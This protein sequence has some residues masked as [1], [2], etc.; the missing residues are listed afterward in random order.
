MVVVV[1]GAVV[2]IAMDVGVVN[3]GTWSLGLCLGV[4][5]WRE[6]VESMLT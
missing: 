6:L 5:S 2:D 1:K 3:V 4:F